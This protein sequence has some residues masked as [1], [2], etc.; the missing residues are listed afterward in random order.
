MVDKDHH[1]KGEECSMSQS[2]IKF[3]FA[4]V[5]DG[6]LTLEWWNHVKVM[7][8]NSPRVYTI[9]GQVLPM[10]VSDMA[11]IYFSKE[12][13]KL[14]PCISADRVLQYSSAWLFQYIKIYFA[15]ESNTFVRHE[16]SRSLLTHESAEFCIIQTL[17]EQPMAFLATSGS[18]WT[19]LVLRTLLPSLLP[20]GG[21]R[22]WG[23]IREL[24]GE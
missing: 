21:A 6:Y 3:W 23:A 2:S 15:T 5:L 17:S 10:P 19:F 7:K 11:I 14:S 8:L 24:Q 1:K 9:W 4:S 18:S 12:V 16:E 13:L 20:L 22:P